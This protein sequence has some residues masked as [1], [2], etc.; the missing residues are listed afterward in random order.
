MTMFSRLLS[1]FRYS[2]CSLRRGLT[3]RRSVGFNGSL[4]RRFYYVKPK[5]KASGSGQAILVLAGVTL[6]IT[7]GAIYVLG[8]PEDEIIGLQEQ[9]KYAGE[10][11][12]KAYLLRAKDTILSYKLKFTEPSSQLLLPEPLPHPYQRPYTLLIEVKDIFIHSDYER[13]MGWRHQKRPGLDAFLNALFDYY[14]IVVFTSENALSTH[15]IIDKM[16]PNQYIMYRL[17]R[18]STKYIS[19]EHVKDLTHINRSLNRVIMVDTN[20]LSVKL[21]PENSIILDKWT[22]DIYDTSLKDLGAFLLTIAMSN[23]DDV[24]PVL[25]YYKEQGGNLLETFKANQARLREEEEKRMSTYSSKGKRFGSTFNVFSFKKSSSSSPAPL[26]VATAATPADTP[27]VS[28]A[29]LD[30]GE[31]NKPQTTGGGWLGWLGLK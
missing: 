7:G 25:D 10:N 16:D 8:R 1:S 2:S 26:E 11:P 5:K 21:Q 14:E 23:T 30:G 28:P 3:V 13:N 20:P 6:A 27:F 12:F 15:P 29:P 9:D 19:G 18:D 4:P 24:R 31:T 22:G 17:Y